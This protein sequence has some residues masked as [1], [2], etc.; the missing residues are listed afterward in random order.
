MI[1]TLVDDVYTG[2]INVEHILY[3]LYSYELREGKNL[4]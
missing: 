1:E 3:T 4:M 2:R